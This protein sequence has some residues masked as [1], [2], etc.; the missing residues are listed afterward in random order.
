MIRTKDSTDSDLVDMLP[1]TE[2]PPTEAYEK[3]FLRLT[4][5]LT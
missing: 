4:R 1:N 3:K 5:Q 2:T